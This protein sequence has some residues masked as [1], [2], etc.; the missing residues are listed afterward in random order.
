MSHPVSGLL[1]PSLDR[2]LIYGRWS[3]LSWL[4]QDSIHSLNV[5]IYIY[6]YWMING[7]IRTFSVRSYDI[8]KITKMIYLLRVYITKFQYLECFRKNLTFAL[9]KYA[10][11]LINQLIDVYNRSD[12]L[13]AQPQERESAKYERELAKKVSIFLVFLIYLCL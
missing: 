10:I 12:L 3:C 8:Y 7:L 4:S 2:S 11:N 1:K 13:E 5:Y 6:I 9:K